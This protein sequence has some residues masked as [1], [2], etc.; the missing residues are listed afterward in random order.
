MLGTRGRLNYS[1]S[2]GEGPHP[3]TCSRLKDN[4]S[5]TF[6]AAGPSSYIAAT[7]LSKSGYLS[8]FPKYPKANLDTYLTCQIS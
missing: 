3:L 6:P 2:E 8:N 1:R 4:P 5:L 7:G